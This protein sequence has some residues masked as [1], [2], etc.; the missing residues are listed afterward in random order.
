MRIE[1]GLACRVM[2][3]RTA[4]PAATSACWLGEV[5]ERSDGPINRL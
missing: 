5:P 1:I 2:R 3:F 4:T